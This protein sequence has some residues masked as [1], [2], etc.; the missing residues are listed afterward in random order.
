MIGEIGAG[1]PDNASM[2]I[3][4]PCVVV[5]CLLAAAVG[6][7]A[8]AQGADRLHHLPPAYD[9]IAPSLRSSAA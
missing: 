6:S 3:G 1:R 4:P 9:R 7:P 2:R 8:D 5:A